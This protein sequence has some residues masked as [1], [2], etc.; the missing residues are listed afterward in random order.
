MLR[1]NDIRSTLAGM[2]FEQDKGPSCNVYRSRHCEIRITSQSLHMLGSGT[3]TR[4]DIN[5]I[6][7]IRQEGQMIRIIV[8]GGHHSA[9]L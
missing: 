9:L 6:R 5:S 3:S 7:L 4:M 2:G 8:R 1:M